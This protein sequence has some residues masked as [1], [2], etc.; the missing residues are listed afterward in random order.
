MSAGENF[1]LGFFK[2]GKSSKYYVGIWY[3]KISTQTPAWIAN[4][5]KHVSDMYSS[6][7]KIDNGNLVLVDESK[8]IVWSTNISSTAS[9]LEA[10]LLDDGNL[11][12]RDGKK[13]RLWES[14]N[15]RSF[16]KWGIPG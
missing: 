15:D 14:I 4:R 5:D 9:D 16:F 11:V 2:P 1:K 13:S 12:L 6:Q 8:S 3:N 10:V 7:L